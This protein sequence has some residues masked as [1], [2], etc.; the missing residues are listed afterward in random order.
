[1]GRR[2]KA[3]NFLGNQ[4]TRIYDP[5]THETKEIRGAKIALVD[6]FLG[7]Q[8]M[9]AAAGVFGWTLKDTANATEAI[10]ANQGGGV[11]ALSLTNANEKQEA[12]IYQGDALNFNMDKGVIFEA[13]VAVHTAPTDQAEIYFGLANAYVEGPISEADAGPTVH[14]F[15]CFDGDLV[16]LVFTDDAATD[17]NQKA[18]GVTVVEDAFHVLRIEVLSVTDVRFYI[19]DVR[20]AAST[21]FGMSNGT[22]VVVQPFLICHKEAGAGVGAAYVDKVSI[23]QLER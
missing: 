23:W 6:D 17:N 8:I 5:A 2:E 15:F 18:T 20:V 21:T 3:I 9:T 13:R 11:V 19:D 4:Y 1:M 10:L 7:T 14:A 16:C 12:G 22:N